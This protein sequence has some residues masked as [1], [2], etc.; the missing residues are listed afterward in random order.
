[1]CDFPIMNLNAHASYLLSIIKI[2][3]IEADFSGLIIDPHITHQK[4]SFKSPLISLESDI[5]ELI[6]SYNITAQLD[7]KI[8][9]KKPKW[10]NEQSKIY[11]NE[12]I[13]IVY[14]LNN[15]D[16]DGFIEIDIPS[17]VGPLV[18]KLTKHDI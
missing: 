1:M 8:K 4:F 3:G 2:A 15:E 6:L 14:I 12:T 18:I 9:I 10:W 13:D 11:L 16:T 5:D 17:N 7:Y